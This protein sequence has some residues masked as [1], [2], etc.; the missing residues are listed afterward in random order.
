MKS[1][2]LLIA[3]LVFI[4][5]CSSNNSN[6]PP[7]QGEENESLPEQIL[8]LSPIMVGG[9][10]FV[11]ENPLDFGVANPSSRQK[12]MVIVIQNPTVSSIALSL[13]PPD[14]A[15]GFSIKLNRCPGALLPKTSCTITLSFSSRGL[16]TGAATGNLLVSADSSSLSIALSATVANQPNPNTLEPSLSY[17]MSPF[18]SGTGATR[19]LVVSNAGPGDANSLSVSP[20]AG[21]VIW[22]NRCPS[23]LA[24]GKSC[25]VSLQYKD[26]RRS[27]P[28]AG[29][30]TIF[31]SS[32]ANPGG[33]SIIVSSL[34]GVV[35]GDIVVP[36]VVRLNQSSIPAISVMERNIDTFTVGNVNISLSTGSGY[37]DIFI[38]ADSMFHNASA[39]AEC[40]T[41]MNSEIIKIFAVND[42]LSDVQF[43]GGI[44]L[45]NIQCNNSSPVQ[46]NLSSLN[47]LN[48]RRIYNEPLILLI[49]RLDEF[50]DPFGIGGQL[51]VIETNMRLYNSAPKLHVSSIVNFSSS[52]DWF[53][54]SY[55]SSGG[56]LVF[57]D[58]SIT[59]P[60]HPNLNQYW[61]H[62]GCSTNI[63]ECSL[64][65]NSG[66][67]MF[68]GNVNGFE[69][70]N[71]NGGCG[72]YN[73][74]M[75]LTLC[76]LAL[77]NAG[78]PTCVGS[79][80]TFTPPSCICGNGEVN[81]MDG[82]CTCDVSNG[83]VQ[84]TF[85]GS[86]CIRATQCNEHSEENTCVGNNSSQQNFPACTWFRDMVTNNCSDYD[87][88][89]FSC[90]SMISEGCSWSSSNDSEFPE[91]GT[92]SGTYQWENSASCINAN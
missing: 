5:G 31:S 8:D 35:G 18:N 27:A 81:E 42:G 32:P 66:S 48:Q 74:E 43:N 23:T 91:N 30:V 29:N 61:A 83:Y 21:Y 53:S 39:T 58:P 64:T 70:R 92:C 59:D 56:V 51:R 60:I 55:Y 1:F 44:E 25:S 87:N 77:G 69:I 46:L 54:P 49:A 41:E 11:T 16:F 19:N 2:I 6:T 90:E 73:G 57:E 14:S 72:G 12:T 38:G 34:T 15:S 33:S 36:P 65:S 76:S 47:N 13:T 9:L 20:P 63:G 62:L 24:A 75:E 28:V 10:D 3:S 4:S 45:A 68:I 7:S 85:N 86:G 88:S 89:Q 82:S 84:D 78:N 67:G 17:T 50:G 37:N 79:T 71:Y 80:I 22:T 52:G 40:P 26:H